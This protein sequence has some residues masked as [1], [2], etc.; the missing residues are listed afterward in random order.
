MRLSPST[1]RGTAP[2]AI[3]S[4]N[5]SADSTSSSSVVLHAPMKTPS[6]ACPAASFT[7][8]TLSGEKGFATCGTSFGKS[9]ACVATYSAPSSARKNSAPS[10]WDFRF[11]RSSAVCSSAGKM[12]FNPPNSAVMFDTVKRKSVEKCSSASPTY[13]TERSIATVLRPSSPRSSR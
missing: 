7:S 3:A 1:F 8:N 2:A 10:L 5:T 12:P 9:K 4:R 13:S 11:A 6:S